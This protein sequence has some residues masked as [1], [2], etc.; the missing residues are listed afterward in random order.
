MEDNRAI[1]NAGNA[2][3]S[4]ANY[5]GFLVRCTEDTEW[6]FVGDQTLHGKEAVRQWMAESYLEPPQNEVD[7]LI[8]ERNFLI[9]TGSISVKNKAGKTTKSSYCDV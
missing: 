2:A 5:E 1:L 7:A 6:V 3:I 4:N 8:A 9:A